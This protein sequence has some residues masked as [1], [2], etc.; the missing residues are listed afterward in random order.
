[1]KKQKYKTLSFDL[2]TCQQDIS[3]SIWAKGLKL[4]QLIGGDE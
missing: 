4:G 2:L 3:K 1:M